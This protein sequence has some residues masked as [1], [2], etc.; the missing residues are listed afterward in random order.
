MKSRRKTLPCK[1]WALV[2]KHYRYMGRVSYRAMYGMTIFDTKSHARA[3]RY[4]L[5]LLGAHFRIARVE[6]K[7]IER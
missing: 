5:G 1:A 4:G 2:T 3:Y 6:I 7:E